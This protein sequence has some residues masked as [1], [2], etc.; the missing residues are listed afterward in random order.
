MSPLPLSGN[1]P[2]AAEL[3]DAVDAETFFRERRP[4]R[5]ERRAEGR[6]RRREV[7]LRS[8][9][10]LPTLEE[11]ADPVAV[12]RRQES[13]R[14]PA[15]VPLRYSRMSVDPFAFFRGSAAVMAADLSRLPTSGMRVWLCGDAHLA[16]FGLF[17]SAERTLVFDLND[18][19]ETLPGPFDWDVKRLAASFAIAAGTNGFSDKVA[20][21][22]S[23][24]AVT[25]YRA[26]MA[27]LSTMRTLDVWYSRL[28]ADRLRERLRKT[29]LGKA[30]VRA[31]DKSL[32]RTGDTALL[33]LTDTVDGARRFRSDP[34]LL[35]PVTDVEFERVVDVLAPIWTEYLRTLPPDRHALLRKF[36]FV[37]IARKVVGVGSVGTRAFVMLLESGDGEPLLLQVKQATASVLE[38]Y[39]GASGFDNHGKRVV[40]GQ[41][42]MQAAGDPFLGWCTGQ[43]KVNHFYIRQ[44]WDMKGAF[45]ATLMDKDA[46]SVYARLCGGMLARAHARASSPAAI[47]GYLGKSEDFDDAVAEFSLGYARITADDH[48]ALAAAIASS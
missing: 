17:A 31:S 1:E 13:T 39:L 8:H 16:N 3:A 7:P 40:V 2:A 42:V 35:V 6:A 19:D 5:E 28:D 12:L 25:S 29:S 41:R 30:A 46:L 21:R 45:D 48:A 9:A 20:R 44:L 47:S 14:E 24:H 36:S 22:V 37:D 15:L 11:R 33:K 4:T 32:R 27:S 43:D 23:K 26:A 10:T 18:F 34:P 38:E